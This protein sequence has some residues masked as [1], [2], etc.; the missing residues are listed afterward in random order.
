VR[1]AGLDQRSVVAV[2]DVAAR[3]D[4]GATGSRIH[5]AMAHDAQRGRTVLFGG[6]D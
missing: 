3:I 2:P 4:V 5:H 1:T 6:S